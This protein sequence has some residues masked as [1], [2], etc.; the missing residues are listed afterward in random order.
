VTRD[1][2]TSLGLLLLGGGVGAVGALA[3]RERRAPAR[4]PTS[5]PSEPTQ[6]KEPNHTDGL[7]AVTWVH[8]VPTLSG[9][10]PAVISSGFRASPAG[11][12]RV[13]L[14]ADV[15][16]R[17][18]DARD[19]VAAFPPGTPGGTPLFFMPDGIPALAASAGVVA[20]AANT[21]QGNSVIL[22]HSDDWA[23]YYTHLA[24]LAVRLGASVAARDVLGTIGASPADPARL[25]HLHFELWRGGTRAGAIDPTPLL[26]AWRRIDLPWPPVVTSASLV[27]SAQPV[28]RNASL[29][30]YRAVGDRGQPYP[31]WVRALRDAS[32]V[33][34]IREIGGPIVYVGSS[35]RRLYDTVTRHFQIWR[36]YKGF[37][38]GQFA[39]GADPGF[40]YDRGKVEVAVKLTPPDDAH[41]EELRLIRRLQP[42]D[43]QI[44]QP[45]FEDAPF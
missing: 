26:D 45:E 1:A 14:G 8:P 10:R 4:T 39:E 36:R 2:D 12:A 5:E 40:T 9:D 31:A 41:D 38:R 28:L 18:R 35:V 24:T 16:Y 17:R 19:L 34:V 30:T 43:N 7:A 29:S 6:P 15:M 27:A 33:Y 20:F 37:W 23:T 32:G 11:K 25:R 13:H 42:R 44:G 21:A 3:W 22:R